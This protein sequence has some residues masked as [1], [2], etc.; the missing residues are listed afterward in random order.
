MQLIQSD[1][2]TDCNEE[3]PLPGRYAQVFRLVQK[4]PISPLKKIIN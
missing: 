1:E 3:D 4:D 2:K